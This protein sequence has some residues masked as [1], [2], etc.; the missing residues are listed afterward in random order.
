MA[1]KDSL[2][3][4]EEL[5]ATGTPEAQAKTTAHQLGDV[6]NILVKIEKDLMWMRVIGAAMVV[7]FM[8]NFFR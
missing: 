4:Y 1:Y 5:I 2:T 7:A 6:T 8:A 3:L